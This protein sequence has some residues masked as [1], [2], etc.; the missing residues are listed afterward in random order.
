MKMKKT[1]VAIALIAGVIASLE[2]YIYLDP[3]FVKASP[4]MLSLE[5]LAPGLAIKIG[6]VVTSTAATLLNIEELSL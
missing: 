5:P 4:T 1:R 3:I 2:S 6:L